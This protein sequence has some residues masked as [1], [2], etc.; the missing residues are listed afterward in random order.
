[1]LL[2]DFKKDP[3]RV[4]E[5]TCGFINHIIH[6]SDLTGM[7][8]LMDNES[9]DKMAIAFSSCSELL[10]LANLGDHLVL[11]AAGKVKHNIHTLFFEKVNDTCEQKVEPMFKRNILL[12]CM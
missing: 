3:S 2:R 9:L 10:H 11:D 6:L 5:Q 12:A 8:S 4:L 7:R 1:M